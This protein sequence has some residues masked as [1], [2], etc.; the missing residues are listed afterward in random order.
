MEDD[1]Y[2]AFFISTD[3]VGK[4]ITR[5]EKFFVDNKN[6][7]THVGLV[8]KS[9]VINDIVP[10][11]KN[12]KYVIYESTYSGSINDNIR[13]TCGSEFFGVQFRDFDLLCKNYKERHQ[14]IAI[15]SIQGLP[16]NYKEVLRRSV[17][18]H[19]NKSYDLTL[20]NLLTIH[21]PLP[22]I[23]TNG[24]FCSDL[25]CKVLQ[26]LGVVE[27]LVNS[28]KT[29]PNTLYQ[30]LGSRINIPLYVSY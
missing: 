29:S 24:M 13:N 28:K 7:F 18:T 19:I 9:T 15:S 23:K 2:V 11:F 20:I 26:D 5:F 25:V 27:G 17:V 16:Q 22:G 14:K 30:L 1:V 8:I 6:I 10:C 21:L 4:V 3:I 12:C